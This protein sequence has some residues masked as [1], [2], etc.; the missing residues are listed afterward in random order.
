[1]ERKLTI[2]DIARIAGVS[3][4]TV[5]RVLNQHARVNPETRERILHVI[6]EHDFA[7]SLNAK[8]L[9]GQSQLIGM[10]VPALSWSLILES[11]QGIAQVAE[12]SAYEIILYSFM[13]NKDFSDVLDRVMATRLTAGLLAMLQTQSTAHLLELYRQGIPIVLV[14]NIGLRTE[15]PLVVADNYGGAYQAV[16]YLTSLGHRRIAYI[17]GPFSLPCA[18]DRYQGYCAALK[19]VGLTPDPAL[20]QQ[21]RFEIVSGRASTE[22][23]LELAEPPTAIF[24]AND[25]MA[26]GVLD[27]A[28]MHGLRVPEDLSVIGFDDIAPSASTHPA[29]TTIRQPFREMGQCA[30]ELLL[31]LL[32][33][34]RPL[35]AD[36]QKFA[37]DYRPEP[38]ASLGRE[39]ADPLQIQLPTELIVRE[40]CG[41]ASTA[42]S[43]AILS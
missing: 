41:L 16:R 14:N 34:Q 21:G 18:H 1:M 9:R 24:A 15:L 37:I 3:K 25:E 20:F 19:D 12:R 36:W 10:L 43:Q 39:Q 13:A 32:D 40:T 30:A 33:A 22:A 8:G 35:S 6:A 5:S 28:K 7:P 23:L 42:S 38:V 17:S 2:L 26:Y 29:L 11:I 31:S 4:S 27:V